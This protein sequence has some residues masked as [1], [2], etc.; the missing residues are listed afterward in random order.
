MF[1]IV[2]LNIIFVLIPIVCYML[3][4]VYENV[5]GSKYNDL[6][7]GFA[8]V[9][10]IYL[11]TKYSLNFNYL[12]SIIK[13]LFLICL[14]KNKNILSALICIY[15]SIYYGIINNYSILMFFVEYFIEIIVLLFV[16]KNVK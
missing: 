15:L 10:S 9:T 8:I 2:L 12:T 14:L 3:Y 11:I 6:F 5:F 16:I 1:D 13:V 4:S 7:F